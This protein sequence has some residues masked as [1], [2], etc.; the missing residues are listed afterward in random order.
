MNKKIL[1][2]KGLI[3][4]LTVS[5]SLS[6]AIPIKAQPPFKN[7]LQVEKFDDPLLPK[8][9]VQRP[10][11]PL[12]KFRLKEAL[13]GLNQQARENYQ[14]GKIERAFQVWYRELRLR[15]KL[16][17]PEE[18]QALGRVGEIAWLE[19]RSADFRNIRERL[20][21]IEEKARENNNSE[22]LATL[23]ENYEQMREL[24][25]A[26]AL[27]QGL[28]E[29]SNNPTT[30]LEKIAQLHADQFHYQ[31][32]A[33]AYEKLLAQAKPAENTIVII[34]YLKQLKTWYEQ[35]ENPQAGIETKQHLIELYQRQN[36]EQALPA[37]M[38][39]LGEDYVT[40]QQFDQA[41]TTYQ[42]AFRIARSQ[43]KY[44]IAAMALENL[45]QLYQNQ[46]SLQATLE[47][48]EQLLIVQQQ[49]YD[50]YGLMMTYDKIGEIYQ[51][52]HQP[53]PAR[54]AYQKALEFARSLNYQEDYFQDKIQQLKS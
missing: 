19:N 4:S 15:Q 45:A 17:F 44:A 9:P 51:D 24:D 28:I 35:A 2:W 26:I 22:L 38:V 10:L 1:F 48:Y 7:P 18:V 34:N 33:D 31:E 52:N 30:L 14:Q 50:H 49:S 5:F 16:D 23:A 11:S 20:R 37:I 29:N 41:S 36:N 25:G 46:G 42:E 43:Q 54:S 27:Y 13:D 39:S 32:A 8:T 3:A 47:I 12:E 21:V 40:L 53:E 6:L